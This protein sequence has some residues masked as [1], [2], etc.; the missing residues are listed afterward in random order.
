MAL[1]QEVAR[2]LGRIISEEVPYFQTAQQTPI[3]ISIT[4]DSNNVVLN[5]DTRFEQ[6]MLLVDRWIKEQAA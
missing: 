1:E 5:G 3:S 2:D 4:G 6:L